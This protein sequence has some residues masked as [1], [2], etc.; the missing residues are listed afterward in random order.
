[1]A[2][3][4]HRLIGSAG[5]LLLLAACGPRY[6]TF[7]AYEPPVAHGGLKCVARCME[8]RRL[9]RREKDVGVQQCRIDARSTADGENLRAEGLYQLDLQRFQAGLTPAAPERPRTVAPDYAGCARQG[10]EIEGQC[11]ADFDLCYQTCGGRVTY[12]T[13][14]VANCDG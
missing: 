14:C 2:A 8:D 3:R 7:T 1:M 5:M 10:S 12:T 9:C 13:H 6:Q 11:G 4:A